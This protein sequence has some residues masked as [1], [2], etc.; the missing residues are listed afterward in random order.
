MKRE[1]QHEPTSEAAIPRMSHLAALIGCT[2]RLR[3]F[4]R[5]AMRAL[6][7]GRAHGRLP[8]YVTGEING[9]SIVLDLDEAVD[10]KAFVGGAFDRRGLGLMRRI[11]TTIGCRTALDIGAN[12]GNHSAFFGDWAEQVYAF[13]LNQTVF[14][15]LCSWIAVNQ[16]R[17]IVPIGCGLSNRNDKLTV[18]VHPGQAGL[19]TL[20]MRDGAIDAGQVWVRI[21]DEL[22]QELVIRD[23]D[24]IKLDVEGHEFEVLQGLRETVARDRPVIVMEFEATSIRKFGSFAGLQSALPGYRFFGTSRRSL[25]SRFLKDGLTLTPFVF[26]RSY[27]HVV[28]W[29]N[30][31]CPI[32]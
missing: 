10:A 28:C 9:R 27:S 21:G 18:F 30:N 19:T 24:F 14:A 7:V 11:M 23:V 4:E 2:G 29:P 8:K 20:E 26:G 22:L 32:S 15:R 6:T 31:N 13:E 5:L 1:L 3:P 25:R 16:M 12:I 17:N